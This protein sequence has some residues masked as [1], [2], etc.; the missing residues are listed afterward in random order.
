MTAEDTRL[1]RRAFL[2]GMIALGAASAVGPLLTACGDG[3]EPQVARPSPVPEKSPTPNPLPTATVAPEPP[4][5]RVAFV[6]ADNRAEGVRRAVALFRPEGLRDSKVLLKPNLNSAHVSPGS[7]HPDTLRA[8]VEVLQGEG[9]TH[10][11]LGERSGFDQGTR[12]V[13]EQTGVFALSSELGFDVLPFDEMD[14][15][16]WVKMDPEGSHWPEGFFVPR[17]L[18]EV[19]AIV[20]TC[21]LKTHRAGGHFTISLKNSVGVVARQ[22]PGR[23]HDYMIDLHVAPGEGGDA[24]NPHQRHMIAEINV[25]YDPKLIVMDGLVA[26]TTG[27]PAVGTRV[28]TQVFLAASDRVALDAVG[29]A[30]LRYWST[31]PEVSQGPIFEQEQIAR[32][33]ELGLGARSPQEIELVTDDPASEEYAAA[34][35]TLLDQ[36]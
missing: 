22:V 5:S 16:G 2:R 4:L 19:D 33:V 27:G 9:V 20:Q 29:V 30:I 21:N 8:L 24:P 13:M 35:R 23:D 6:K 26:L 36:G 12:V 14:E 7:T 15:A 1:S 18:S 10:I 17:F 11:T 32:A 3:E 25:A 31:T 34:V 28:D